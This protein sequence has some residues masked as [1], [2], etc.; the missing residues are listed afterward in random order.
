[1]RLKIRDRLKQF[2]WDSWLVV[3]TMFLFSVFAYAG[4]PVVRE[5]H[6]VTCGPDRPVPTDLATCMH[7]IVRRD[8]KGHE[9]RTFPA[10]RKEKRG[11]EWFRCVSDTTD[12]EGLGW[13][14]LCFKSVECPVCKANAEWWR[15]YDKC[16]LLPLASRRVCG[17]QAGIPPWEKPGQTW[18]HKI[19]K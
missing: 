13:Q 14:D 15:I 5:E 9:Y 10:N 19:K 16:D 7:Y 1:M 12:F 2:W 8:A 17:K 3:G 4:D 6:P 11:R 18:I